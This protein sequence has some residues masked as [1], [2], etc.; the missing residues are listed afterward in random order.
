MRSQSNA[1]TEQAY[2]L[3]CW[4]G[5]RA[6]TVVCPTHVHARNEWLL[7][8]THALRTGYLSYIVLHSPK[9]LNKFQWIMCAY[10]KLCGNMACMLWA[11][12][13]PIDMGDN[14]THACIN[15][16]RG[17][18]IVQFHLISSIRIAIFGQS[19]RNIFFFAIDEFRAAL[20]FRVHTHKCVWMRKNW[21]NRCF[22]THT[23]SISQSW[24]SWCA[25]RA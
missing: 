19:F 23:R 9:R 7:N 6:H 14:A 22:T 13:G 24:W 20:A 5:M 12:Q 4:R 21:E 3:G 15:V 18:G 1:E 8:A 17:Y 2:R 16:F 11:L 10:G 25:R